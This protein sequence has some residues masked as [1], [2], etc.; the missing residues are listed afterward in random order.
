[1][2]NYITNQRVKRVNFQEK[3]IQNLGSLKTKKAVTNVYLLFPS[4]NKN[5]LQ[6]VFRNYKTIN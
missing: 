4:V 6:R 3:F 2:R 5:I 1:M